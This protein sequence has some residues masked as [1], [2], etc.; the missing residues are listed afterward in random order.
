M[1]IALCMLQIWRQDDLCVCVGGLTDG[2]PKSLCIA[3]MCESPETTNLSW[4][5]SLYSHQHWFAFQLGC[6]LFMMLLILLYT[7]HTLYSLVLDIL[8]LILSYNEGSV[9]ESYYLSMSCLLNIFTKSSLLLY[10]VL[11]I[12][13]L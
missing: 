9:Y 5:M 1:Y 12:F 3:F 11:R 8:S 2:N 6:F 10:M 7:A 4:L 13:L